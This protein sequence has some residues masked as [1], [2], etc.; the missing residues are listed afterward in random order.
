LLLFIGKRFEKDK[1]TAKIA[2][3]VLRNRVNGMISQQINVK[4]FSHDKAKMVTEITF[5]KN[6]C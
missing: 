3:D 5:V 2:K 1:D 6:Q 4:N